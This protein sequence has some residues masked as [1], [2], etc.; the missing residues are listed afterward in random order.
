[1]GVLF[2]LFFFCVVGF[3]FIVDLVVVGVLL[4]GGAINLVETA[5]EAERREGDAPLG[6]GGGHRRGG[7]LVMMVVVVGTRVVGGP[8][9][10]ACSWCR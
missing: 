3:V 5:F 7:V 9:C 4:L 2:L 6:E 8:L 1:V 10:T